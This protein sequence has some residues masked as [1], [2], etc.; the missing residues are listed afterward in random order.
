MDY[1]LTSLADCTFSRLGFLSCG[2]SHRQTDR[3]TDRITDADDC[4][5]DATTVGVSYVSKANSFRCAIDYRGS[6]WSLIS[7]QQFD[8]SEIFADSECFCVAK[9]VITCDVRACPCRQIADTDNL[10][11]PIALY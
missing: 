7:W 11:I 5:N 1:P 6:S 2:Q 3:Q 8:A 9:V 4:Y 10:Q